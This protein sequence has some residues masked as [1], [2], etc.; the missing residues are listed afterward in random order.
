[1]A[2]AVGLGTAGWRTLLDWVVLACD[3]ALYGADHWTA[4]HP[5]RSIR[6][7]KR[8]HSGDGTEILRTARGLARLS[9]RSPQQCSR[10]RWPRVHRCGVQGFPEPLKEGLGIEPLPAVRVVVRRVPKIP[11]RVDEL[12]LRTRCGKALHSGFEVVHTLTVRRQGTLG[13]AEPKA[14]HRRPAEVRVKAEIGME[15]RVFI[16]S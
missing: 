11:D 2:V 1:M 16:S 3:Q 12:V 8:R 6:R 4:L 13:G 14:E 5:W 9:N 15:L 7:R 10:H